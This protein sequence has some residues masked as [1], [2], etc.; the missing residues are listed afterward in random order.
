[1]RRNLIVA[2][3]TLTAVAHQCEAATARMS[4]TQASKLAKQ[5]NAK[6]QS[7]LG[8]IYYDKKDY[9]NALYWYQAAA[10]NGYA[11]G[12]WLLGGMYRDGLGVE[13]DYTEAMRL[14]KLAVAK[15]NARAQ[16]R[17]ICIKMA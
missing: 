16:T 4:F 8:E 7:D 17:V 9:S 2:V 12:L 3:L 13:Q 15:G 1:M 11:V 10:D 14:F 6:A 5:G